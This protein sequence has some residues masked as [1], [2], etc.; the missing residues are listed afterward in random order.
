M[1]PV[2]N[3]Q[4][5]CF[6]DPDSFRS[7]IRRILPIK[8]GQE[9][10]SEAMQKKKAKE[11]AEEASSPNVKEARRPNEYWAADFHWF[12]AAKI[13]RRRVLHDVSQNYL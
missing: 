13:R 7:F 3:F 9:S 11:A 12:D 10:I 1:N 8:N 6:S 4:C 2:D 5:T